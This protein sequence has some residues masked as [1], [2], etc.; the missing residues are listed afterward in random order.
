[1]ARGSSQEWVAGFHLPGGGLDASFWGVKP[2]LLFLA[3]VVLLLAANLSA[4]GSP[5]MTVPLDAGWRFVLQEG[6]N[7][8]A[9]PEF[10]DRGWETVSLP[11]TWNAFDGQDGGSN[12]FRG[13]GWYR[14]HFTLP[15]EA[16]GRRVLVEF[17]AASRMADVFV[18]GQAVGSHMGAF[19]RFRFDI[20]GRV[21]WTGDNVLA[22]RVNN[23]ANDFIPR[24][25]DFTQGGG[26]YRHAR[27]L[28]TAPAH[29]ATLDYASPGVELVQHQVSTNRA[30]VDAVVKLANDSPEEFSGEVEVE[31]WQDDSNK[32]VSAKTEVALAP[33]SSAVAALPL[34]ISRP[35]LWDGVADPFVYR[36]TISLLHEGRVVDAIEQPLGL[37]SFEVKPDAG[38]FLNGR[39]VAL[40]GVARHQDRLD[41]G[42]AISEDDMR[43]DFSILRELGANAVR[44]A[45]YQHD[46]FF[47][48]LCDTGGVAVWAELCFVNEPPE[49]E[50]GRANAKEQLRELIRQN[51]NHPAIFFWSVGN[52]TSGKTDT[53]TAK[54]ADRLVTE[55]AAVVREED[56]TR[57]STYA[58]NHQPDDPRNFR[59]DVVGVNKYFGWYGGNYSDLG[60]WLDKFHA[61]HPERCLGISEYGAGASI[62]QHE[63]N[64]PVRN[65]QSRGPWHPEEWQTMFHEEN[66]LQIKQRPWIWGA[67]I[68]NLFDF[69]ADNRAEG[70][71]HGRNDKG[72]ATYDRQVRKDAF[73]W[74]Q[75]NWTTNAMVHIVSKRFSER[76]NPRTEIRV[77]SNG[78]EVEAILNGVSLGKTN[79][80]DCRFVWPDVELQPGVNRIEA[81][82]Y[83]DGRPVAADF[84]GW[85]F[86]ADGDPLPNKPVAEQDAEVA[87]EKA[88]KAAR[89]AGQQ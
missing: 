1:M 14:T 36:A 5:R 17:D 3:P 20:T 43:Q 68:W 74:Y 2:K 64:P 19:A 29:L 52:E 86:R 39:H 31:V 41:K 33:G 13:T 83:R 61:D 12:Y 18:N 7:G 26:L 76:S 11:H 73:Y 81:V 59:T 55:L 16:K 6:S 89:Q 8:W 49:T 72:L 44:L 10:D 79:S 85:N 30:D 66:W 34:E 27:L 54:R 60:K 87:K 62:Y 40:H 78:D 32:V 9:A 63:E 28:L 88:E 45:H 38:F 37:R 24:G 51:F 82:A 46:Q 69:A 47:Y 56:P 25:G 15:P 23:A 80:A 65:R 21:H 22:V 50:A 57:L 42:W 53:A 77:Y 67:F 84:G 70:D 35:R 71:E 48:S 4:A 58:S 75:A